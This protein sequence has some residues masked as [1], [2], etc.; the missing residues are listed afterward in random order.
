MSQP[1]RDH[2]APV[3]ESVA[4]G[5]LLIAPLFF[6]SNILVG[7]ALAEITPPWT[8]T[9][10]RWS[11]ALVVV[12]PFAAPGLW[13]ARRYIIGEWRWILLLGGFAQGVCGAFV[14][15]ALATT[16]ATN[17]GLIYS[18]APLMIIAIA[19]A[20]GMERVAPR[21]LIGALIGLVG[22]LTIILKGDPGR[23]LRLDFTA[24]DLWILFSTTGWAIYSVLLRLRPLRLRPVENFAVTIM[25]GLLVVLPGFL[26]E[27]ATGARFD[28]SP[29]ALS[30]LATLALISSVAAFVSYITGQAVVGAGKAGLFMYLM[31]VYGTVLAV[32]L[33]GERLAAYHY[34]GIVLIILGIGL[35]SKRRAS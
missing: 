32:L 10:L 35:A 27:L 3:S 31:P 16:T 33:L 21:A 8:L 9:F 20:I 28:P 26:W 5:L 15:I 22:V 29:A 18:A 30:G 1:A 24:G 7:R 12:L 14:Y 6:S 25:G 34:V 13:A 11:L 19:A 4:Y 17:G 2:A 23:L